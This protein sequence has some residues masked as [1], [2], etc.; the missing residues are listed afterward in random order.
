MIGEQVWLTIPISSDTH[1]AL[2]MYAHNLEQ[3]TG[4]RAEVEDIAVKVL[5]DFHENI[6]IERESGYF[7]IITGKPSEAS[8]SV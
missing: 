4:L 5:E 1:N 3:S 7:P 6:L 2:Q 8:K